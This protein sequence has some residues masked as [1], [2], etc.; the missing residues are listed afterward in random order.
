MKVDV[1]VVCLRLGPVA[2]RRGVARKLAAELIQR[3]DKLMYEAKGQ[4]SSHVHTAAVHVPRRLSELTNSAAPWRE[5]RGGRR[6]N[7]AR[8]RASRQQAAE[9]AD[10]RGADSQR[11]ADHADTR[12]ARSSQRPQGPEALRGCRPLPAGATLPRFYPLHRWWV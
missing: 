9:H 2:E 8:P 7:A 1:G 4:Q 10:R 5:G 12:G 11:A 3:A 6:A